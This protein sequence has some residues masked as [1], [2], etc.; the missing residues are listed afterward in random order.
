[1]DK[2]NVNPN[3][4]KKKMAETDTTTD[5]YAQKK[6]AQNKF[7]NLTQKQQDAAAK[8]YALGLSAKSVARGKM[9]KSRKSRKTRKS[10]KSRKT[11]KTKGRQRR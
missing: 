6:T 3:I 11:R 5:I 4:L 1:M 10:R 8:K 9:R 2:E 7:G